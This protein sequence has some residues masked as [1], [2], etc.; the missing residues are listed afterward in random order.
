[1]STKRKISF[2]V[3]YPVVNKTDARGLSQESFRNVWTRLG[4]DGWDTSTDSLNGLMTGVSKLIQDDKLKHCV[5]ACQ[6][7]STDTGPLIEIVPHPEDDLFSLDGQFAQ[8]RS[9]AVREIDKV[10]GQILGLGSHPNTGDSKSE[11]M[12]LRTPRSSY[13]YAIEQ[14]GWPHEKLLTIASIQEVIDVCAADAFRVNRVLTRLC[15]LMMFIFRNSPDLYGDSGLLSTR[16]SKWVQSVTSSNPKFI[17]DIKKV[18]IPEEEVTCWQDYFDLLWSRNPMFLLGTKQHGLC[19]IPDHPNFGEFLTKAPSNGWEG[20]SITGRNVMVSPSMDFVNFTDW[21]YFGFCRPRWKMQSDADMGGL[22][23]AFIYRNMDEFFMEN[24][25]KIMIENRSNCSG[26]PG[27]ELS[28]LAFVL[29]IVENLDD[30]EKFVFDHDYDFWKEVFRLSQF[31]PL[32]SAEV[33]N[34]SIVAL[35][36]EILLISRQGVKSRCL[37]EECF[38]DPIEEII[39]GGKSRS[40]L[41]LDYFNS[42]KGDRS[43]R[44][45]K[46]A[47]K[48]AII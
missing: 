17:G 40:E 2:E 8:L 48:Y 13:D 42:L 16:P 41:V 28:S 12:Q 21:T 43:S 33:N 36:E 22:T 6:S 9:L 15:G 31:H 26:F 3:E 32:S 10:G 25:Q 38:L 14:R 47:S 5:N 18:N 34:I 11:Y 39:E 20:M 1:M 23:K 24:I 37:K 7:I 45:V 30:A 35:A 27:Q 44:A 46:I 29:G 19:Y 4:H